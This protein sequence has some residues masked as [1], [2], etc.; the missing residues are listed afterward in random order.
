MIP[1]GEELQRENFRL[2]KDLSECIKVADVQ[3]E[4]LKELDNV[5]K[6]LVQRDF[7]LSEANERLKELDKLKSEFVSLAAHQLRTPVSIVKWTIAMLQSGDF[8]TLNEEQKKAI[9][10][11]YD[12][13]NG[14]IRLIADLL[15]VSR[16]ESGRFIYNKSKIDIVSLL[17]GI[18]KFFEITAKKKKLSFKLEFPENKKVWL[19]ADREKLLSALENVLENAFIYT[20][21]GGI[22]ITL[23]DLGKNFTIEIKDTGMGIP[24]DQ[25]AFIFDKFFRAKNVIRKRI[26]GTGLGLYLAKSIIEAHDGKIEIQSVLNKGTIILITFSHLHE[27]E[28]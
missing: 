28:K 9:G 23:K 24:E 21:K 7:A 5:A 15:D 12:A 13:I 20:E 6:G 8:G 3:K 1:T 19:L 27:N 2:K 25:L 4:Q 14:L 10:Q 22:T 26:T 16:I 18:T 11:A 17:H